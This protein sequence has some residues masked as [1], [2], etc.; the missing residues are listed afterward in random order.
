MYISLQPIDEGAIDV[1]RADEDT[2]GCIGHDRLF[3][4]HFNFVSWLLNFAKARTAR[5]TSARY[6]MCVCGVNA[7]SGSSFQVF[8]NFADCLL[9]SLYA[10][11]LDIGE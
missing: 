1:G 11:L 5:L 8:F 2:D 10:I 6:H 7:Q 3:T 9:A 4:A